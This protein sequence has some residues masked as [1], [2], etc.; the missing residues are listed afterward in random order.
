MCT[1]A[2]TTT[3]DHFLSNGRRVFGCAM[4]L[5][6]AFDMVEL[7][8]LFS[9]LVTKGVHPV[10]LRVLLYIYKEQQCDVKWAGKQSQRFSVANGVR[11]GAVSSPLLFSIYIDDLFRILRKAGLG[12][13]IDGIFLHLVGST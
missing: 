2:V 13:H 1:W 11:Q 12:C 8:E 3:I 4:D 6:K 9:T 5:S 10:F 7:S